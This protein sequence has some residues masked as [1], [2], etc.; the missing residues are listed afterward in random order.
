MRAGG[1]ATP[2]RRRS[3]LERAW[4][5]ALQ[6]TSVERAKNVS[7][8]RK[9]PKLHYAEKT[10][11]GYVPSSSVGV[12]HLVGADSMKVGGTCSAQDVLLKPFV[13]KFENHDLF[14]RIAGARSS[15]HAD[16]QIDADICF[17]VRVPWAV[18]C[19][20]DS[21]SLTS[22]E[23]RM[24]A[25]KELIQHQRLIPRW[26]SPALQGMQLCLICS[27]RTFYQVCLLASSWL[28]ISI[29]LVILR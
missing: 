26:T 27:R 12:K 18:K 21:A 5:H 20:V 6:A 22:L 23:V 4:P 11:V 3:R 19:G 29:R 13:D 28:I 25:A 9:K 8:L 16:R 2:Y 10:Q 7:P 14:R 24:A 17:E 1:P 15:S